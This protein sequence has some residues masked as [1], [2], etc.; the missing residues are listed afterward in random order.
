MKLKIYKNIILCFVVIIMMSSIVQAKEVENESIKGKVLKITKDVVEK[1]E[2]VGL[3]NRIQEMRIELLNGD[4]KGE[5]TYATNNISSE[6]AYNMIVE[7]GDEVILEIEKDEQGNIIQ[8]HVAEF[9]RD[10]Y[11]LYL[12][13]IFVI[14]I[15]LIGGYKGVK[16]LVSLGIITFLIIKIMVPA[17]LIGKNPISMS[18][19]V[20]IIS[21][22][23]TMLLI[24]GINKKTLAAIFGTS[25]GVISAGIIA[26]MFMNKAKL[27][28]LSLSDA[29]MLRVIPQGT[30]FDFKG[31]LFAGIILG[32]LGAAMDV[33]ISISSSINEINEANSLMTIKQLFKAGMNVGK[34][35]MGTMTNTL[36]LAYA[37]TSLN[38]MILFLAYEKPFTQIINMDMIAS[39]IVRALAG[40]IGLVFTIPLTAIISAYLNANKKY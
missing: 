16:S 34:D 10:K 13:I 14:M 32:A 7:E 27:T 9:V 28:G 5:I 37:G 25:G 15:V 21:T 2:S 4:N 12:F 3:S 22:V 20:A 29:Q 30:E 26:T 36:I 6:M 18:I 19:I 24:G 17:I 40:T 31:I 35:V 39:E 23:L 8:M 33:S 11:L 38:L 1:N